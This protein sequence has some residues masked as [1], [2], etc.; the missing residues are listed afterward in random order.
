MF[1]TLIINFSVANCCN[2][3]GFILYFQTTITFHCLVQ[4][5]IVNGCRWTLYVT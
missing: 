2:V 4:L 1:F 3:D 5:Y